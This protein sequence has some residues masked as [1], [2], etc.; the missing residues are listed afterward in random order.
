MLLLYLAASYR[1]FRLVPADITDFQAEGRF[2]GADF[3][4]PEMLGFGAIEDDVA[5][6]IDLDFGVGVPGTLDGGAI[7]TEELDQLE[8]LLA[9]LNGLLST[10]CSNWLKLFMQSVTR[11]RQAYRG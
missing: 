7:E 10:P 2:G 11:S 3:A 8:T 9:D 6:F 5:V 4:I 1:V